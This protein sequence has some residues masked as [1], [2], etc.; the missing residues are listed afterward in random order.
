MTR[1]DELADARTGDKGDSL[2]LAVVAR[3]EDGF[4]MLAEKLT[5]RA[6]A[7]HYGSPV[8]R[9]SRTELP[10]LRALTF[11]LAGYLGGGVTGS[12]L[13]DGHGKALSYHLLDLDLE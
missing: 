8:E 9:V 6:V 12:S 5:P 13:L 3:S 11:T 4:E 7:E 2:I 1:V 10:H